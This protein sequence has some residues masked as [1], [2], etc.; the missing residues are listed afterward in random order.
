[1][2]INSMSEMLGGLL[3]TNSS[4]VTDGNIFANVDSVDSCANV[5]QYS[6]FYDYDRCA[7]SVCD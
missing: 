4:E 5:Y 7:G 3:T 2:S 1:M 6:T